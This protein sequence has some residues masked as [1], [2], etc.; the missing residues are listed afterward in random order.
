MVVPIVLMRFHIFK[1]SP[2]RSILI[3]D[4]QARRLEFSNINI[5]SLPGAQ[6]HDLYR[7]VPAKSQYDK[8][9]IFAGGNDLY[10]GYLSSTASVEEVTDRIV[11]LAN[12]LLHVCER[13]F[14]LGI[15]AQYPP[16]AERESIQD[17]DLIR[18]FAVN[19]KIEKEAVGARW[20]FRGL[21]EQIYCENHVTERDHVHLNESALSGLR[22]ILKKRV[23]NED[24]S[25]SVGER[26]PKTYEC[27]RATG[28]LCGSYTG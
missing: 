5:L 22:S 11:S 3:A 26:R 13:V 15:P 14:V 4:L 21:S 27:N 9:V 18:H 23:V 2:I 25:V 12:H 8:I 24:F 19:R 28:C 1:D 6:I 17:H 20:V 10:N 16:E 7:F